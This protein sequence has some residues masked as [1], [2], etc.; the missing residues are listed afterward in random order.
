MKRALVL[1]LLVVIGLAF[2]GSAQLQGEW[3]SWLKMDIYGTFAVD[4]YSFLDIQYLVGGWTL[5]A[6]TIVTASGLDS[7]WFEAWGSLGAFSG[8]SFVMFDP[9]T[10][11]QTASFLTFENAAQVSIAGVDII[12]LFAIQDTHAWLEED[13]VAGDIGS[14]F[15]VIGIGQAGDLRLGAEVSWN[16]YS[17]LWSIFMYGLDGNIT[18]WSVTY[19]AS[20]IWS[21]YWYFGGLAVIQSTCTSVFTSVTAIAQFPICCA[22]IYVGAGFN[23]SGFAGLSFLARNIDI[24]IPWLQIY[25]LSLYY[26]VEG[27]VLSHDFKLIVGDVVCFKP[28]LSVVMDGE[29][30]ID[31]I[32]LNA[33]TL[34]CTLGGCEFY[35]GHIFDHAMMRYSSYYWPGLNGYAPFIDNYYFSSVGGGLT[36]YETKGCAWSVEFE[37]VTYYPNEMFGIQCDEDSCCGGLFSFSVNNFFTTETVPMAVDGIFGWMGTYVEL[38]AGIGSNISVVGGLNVSAANGTEY[39]T[40]GFL[41]A[42]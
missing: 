41:V 17:S 39:V 36:Y 28:Y 22:D 12:G 5:E 34:S 21:P 18:D 19:C 35:W 42:W 38:T 16:L 30:I 9:G 1:S 37:E 24:G 3:D 15:A 8:W 27:K 4:F 2:A 10:P 14:G 13:G 26:D 7:I 31:G 33:L 23:C 11:S 29:N 20:D 6:S 40:F 25:D 32:E